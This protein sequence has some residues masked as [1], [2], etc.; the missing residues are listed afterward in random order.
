[1]VDTAYRLP[2]LYIWWAC[3]S[4]QL[5]CAKGRRS[6]GAMLYSARVNSR[7]GWPWWQ[8]YKRC[9]W[10]YEY[11]Y[12]YYYYVPCVVC[13]HL[14]VEGCWPWCCCYCLITKNEWTCEW[15]NVIP[16]VQCGLC[17]RECLHQSRCRR[18]IASREEKL[19]HRRRTGCPRHG[20]S[21]GHSPC[22]RHYH[23]PH[24]SSWRHT[25]TLARTRC[26]RRLSTK[27]TTNQS[28]KS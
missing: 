12:C 23:P 17:W 19:R 5:A 16:V 4:S 1:M 26:K 11:Y 18:R 20:V 24:T 27:V 13:L 15:T 21:S 8:H 3:C 6:P 7:N 22:I 10:Y 28:L 14:L 2:T 25:K 9:H